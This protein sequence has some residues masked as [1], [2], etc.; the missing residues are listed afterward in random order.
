MGRITISI[1]DAVQSDLDDYA[2]SN[3]YN[4]S[5]AV[6]L[7]LKEHFKGDAAPS[8]VPTPETPAKPMPVPAPA[9][10]PVNLT[11]YDAIIA[12]LE[13]EAEIREQ[14]LGNLYLVL[15]NMSVQ[16]ET[17]CGFIFPDYIPSPM[18]Q[19]PVPPWM[20]EQPQKKPAP[21]QPWLPRIGFEN[22][23]EEES[24]ES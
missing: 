1:D 8:P 10:P 5:E 24:E 6:E 17:N 4:R 15:E 7:I 21:N 9:P 13:K 11:K 23:N 18:L 14:Y 22:Q 3:G 20:G 16:L 19:V 12:K 2:R